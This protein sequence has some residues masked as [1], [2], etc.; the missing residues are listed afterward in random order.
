MAD[1]K[2]PYGER[3]ANYLSA[4][5][6]DQRQWA[7][8]LAYTVKWLVEEQIP[9]MIDEAIERRMGNGG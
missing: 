5:V 8:V 3:L 4:R 7:Y 9:M 6:L 1:P 2:K